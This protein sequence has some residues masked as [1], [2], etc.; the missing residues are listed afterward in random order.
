MPAI[1]NSAI[2]AYRARSRWAVDRDGCD[3]V[4]CDTEG[5]PNG[6]GNANKGRKFTRTANGL[7]A[8]AN[9]RYDECNAP[10]LSEALTSR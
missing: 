1:K 3:D 8:G 5:L 10:I 6:G 7:S 2:V 4:V 9:K